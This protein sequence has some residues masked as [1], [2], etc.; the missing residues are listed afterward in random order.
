MQYKGIIA[1][2]Q[3][4]E[5][6]A[7]TVRGIVLALSSVIVFMAASFFHLT[8][9]ANDVMALATDVGMAAGA[10]WTIYGL[11]MKAVVFFG[12]K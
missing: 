1:S 4:P 8:L 9:S 12:K 6:I 11:L 10:V 3:D 7:N 2:S 5:Q